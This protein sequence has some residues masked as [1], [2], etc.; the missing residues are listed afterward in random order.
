MSLQFLHNLPKNTI[1]IR[2]DFSQLKDVK[3][4]FQNKKLKTHRNTY[5]Y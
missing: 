4:S 5:Y 2:Y 3:I 1:N